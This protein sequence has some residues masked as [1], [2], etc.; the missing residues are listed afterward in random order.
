MERALDSAISQTY[1]EIEVIVVDDSGDE[2]AK[3]KC[4][5]Y[6]DVTYL[7]HEGNLGAQA[8]RATGLNHASGEY[9]QFLDD[10]DILHPQKIERQINL[11]KE[12]QE[13]GVVYCGLKI[14]NGKE[15][16]PK[17]GVKGD[18]LAE[19]LRFH[20][21]PIT[22]STLLIERNTLS[23]V[24]PLHEKSYGADDLRL[25]IK[26]AKETKYDYIYDILVMRGRNSHSRGSSWGAV[27]GRWEILSDFKSIYANYD[28]RIR[29][30]AIAKT[31]RM[32][33]KMILKDEYW[34]VHAI[35]NFARAA[36]LD[37]RNEYKHYAMIL[38]ALFG[39]PGIT[40][41]YWIHRKKLVA[42]LN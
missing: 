13:V 3:T 18:I 9:I 26:L 1:E 11:F 12:K 41:A 38:M 17:Q 40:L 42:L 15:I 22:N 28:N 30:E 4:A 32:E 14:Q 35:L 39:R 6:T 29:K 2:H 8:A 37:P 5:E 16:L 34:S 10:D 19:T 23:R 36:I 31:Y 33:A 25:N 21:S 27:R 20:G 24:L 7:S